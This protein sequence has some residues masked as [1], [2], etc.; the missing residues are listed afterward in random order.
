MMADV[1]VKFVIDTPHGP[2][3]D[4]LIFTPAEFAAL[5]PADIERLKQQRVDGWLVAL[6]QPSA[7]VPVDAAKAEL[8]GLLDRVS[9]LAVTRGVDATAMAEIADIR[10]RLLLT[11]QAD[12]GGK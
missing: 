4:A 11:A 9:E 6:D 1:V 3:S 7:D 5:K 10:V 12:V 8:S 2:Y